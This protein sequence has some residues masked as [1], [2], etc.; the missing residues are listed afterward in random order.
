M[1]LRP[2]REKNHVSQPCSWILNWTKFLK[3][4]ENQKPLSLC[5]ISQV[6]FGWSRP[7]SPKRNN[8]PDHTWRGPWWR[9]PLPSG[10]GGVTVYKFLIAATTNYRKLSGSKT[11]MPHRC[12][13]SQFWEVRSSEC[14]MGI[15]PEHRKQTKNQKDPS[16]A[17][18]WSLHIKIL[19]FIVSAKPFCHVRWH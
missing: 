10:C 3:V 12:I 14:L 5:I 9:M 18:A 7:S 17:D 16:H 6:R 2:Q 4:E 19:N 8:S 11:K 1:K 13:L 15:K